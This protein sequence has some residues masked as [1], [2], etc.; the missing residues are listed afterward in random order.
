ML[1]LGIEIDG[2]GFTDLNESEKSELVQKYS[3][4][5]SAENI[6]H[7][8]TEEPE[9]LEEQR[10]IKSRLYLRIPYLKY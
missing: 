2:E 10:K 5:F 9:I 6:D 7:L 1:R 3:E 4:P 8:L